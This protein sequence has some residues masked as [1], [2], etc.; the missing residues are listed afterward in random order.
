MRNLR[1]A[2]L[3]PPDEPEAPP[4]RADT[5]VQAREI[6]ECLSILGHEVLTIV[7]AP[8]RATTESDLVAARPDVVVNLIEDLPIG[9]EHAHLVTRMLEWLHLPYTGAPTPALT[10]L[11][12]KREM[13]ACLADAGLPV[14]PDLA[15]GDRP[16]RY[17]VKSATQH[18][19]IGIDAAS[20][21]EGCEA[22]RALIAAREAAFGGEWFAEAYIDGRE[23]NLAVLQTAEGPMPL[24]VAE[25]LFLDHDDVPKIVGYAEKWAEGSNAYANTPRSFCAIAGE[26]PLRRELVRLGLAAWALF[27]LRGYARVDFRVDDRQTPYILEVN[28]NPCLAADAGFC[29]AAREAGLTQVEIVAQ[30]LETALA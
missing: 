15:D 9:P 20:V 30:L 29:A 28:A 18:A 12:D 17:I 11:G 4:D 24:P 19:S 1:V 13:K 25:I 14:P 26:E 3:V 5:F 21:V 8:E 6:S 22:A 16:V 2:I 7:F 10:M 27:G 23:F